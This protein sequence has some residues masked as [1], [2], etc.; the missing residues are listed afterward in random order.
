MLH[1]IYQT[2]M[3]FRK[4]FSRNITWLMFCMVVLGFIGTHEMRG[5]TSF[6]QFWGLNT[7]GYKALIHFFR[8]SIW[9]LD[10]VIELW[11]EFVLSQNETVMSHG[12]AVLLGD[13]TCVPKDGRQMPCVVTMHQHSETQSKPSYFRGHYWGAVGMLIGSMVAPFCIPLSLGVH[14]GLVHVN[15]KGQK[16]E[17]SE[18]LGTRIIQM[19]FDFVIKHDIPSILTLDAFFP[20]RAVFKLAQSVWSIKHKCPLLTLIIRAKKNCVGYFPAEEPQK[21]GP[22]RP[23]QYGEKIKIFEWFDHLELFER[24]ECT[25]YGKIEMVSITSLDLLWKPTKGLIRFVLA[26]TKRGPIILMC[27]DLNQNPVAA[28]ELYCAR[29]RIET[30][31][32]MLKNLMGVFKY[33]FWTQSLERHSRK[34]KKN[35]HLKKPATARQMANVKRCFAAYERFVMIGAIGLG[36]LQ[37]ISI[38]HESSVWKK[39][40]GFLRTRSRKLPSERTVKFVIADLLVRDLFSSATGAVMRKIQAYIFT[41][42][43]VESECQRANLKEEPETTVIQT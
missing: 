31:F 12:R 21:K 2:L 3:F 36:L 41:Q 4:A 23:R 5:V 15:A 42:K 19:A 11:W 40:N 26:V 30:M 16:E 6:C 33:R 32:D 39:F 8:V 38:K 24:V 7:N 18:T 28:L 20:G 34:P 13:H 35:K 1:Y 22:G 14:Q 25:I 17:N 9:S 10:K 43:M 37:L 27:S 29:V